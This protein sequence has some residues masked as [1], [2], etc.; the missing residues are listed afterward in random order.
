MGERTW[1]FVLR[2][3]DVCEVQRLDRDGR[4]VEAVR[5]APGANSVNMEG[6][7]IPESVVRLA[8][9]RQSGGQYADAEGRLLDWMGRPFT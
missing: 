9:Q 3:D 7:T 5:F 1:W 6:R 2:T 4:A 8:E